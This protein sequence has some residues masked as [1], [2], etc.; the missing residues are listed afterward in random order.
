ML[1]FISLSSPVDLFN[2]IPSHLLWETIQPCCNYCVK[3]ACT[4]TTIVFIHAAVS[5]S[6][7]QCRVKKLAQDLTLQHRIQTRVLL[8]EKPKLYP[9]YYVKPSVLGERYLQDG[10]DSQLKCI[11]FLK[12]NKLHKIVWVD[13]ILTFN[14]SFLQVL[15]IG[16]V[17][18]VGVVEQGLG[19]NAAHIEARPTQRVILL[20]THCLWQHH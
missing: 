3:A 17:V 5:N 4:I 12:Y 7:E 6:P 8:V 13:D 10:R 14:A 9:W 19:R 1:H 16:H 18:Q 15:V 11:L 20:H 2:Q